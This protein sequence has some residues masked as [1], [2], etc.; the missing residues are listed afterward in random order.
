MNHSLDYLFILNGFGFFVL[1]PIVILVFVWYVA[2]IYFQSKA[3]SAAKTVL[4]VKLNKLLWW[5]SAYPFLTFVLTLI[6]RDARGIFSLNWF[7][8]KSFYDAIVSIA[9]ILSWLGNVL[10]F[11]GG[12]LVKF[13]EKKSQRIISIRLYWI[14]LAWYGMILLPSVLLVLMVLST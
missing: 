10:F 9:L 6:N 13:W 2:K 5:V 8:S 7:D 4:A 1:Q 3:I 14:G 11:V 12:I